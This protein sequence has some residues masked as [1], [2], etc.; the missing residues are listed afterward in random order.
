MSEELMY[1]NNLVLLWYD[2]CTSTVHIV[3]VVAS[4]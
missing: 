4:M 2:E 1:A 3:C